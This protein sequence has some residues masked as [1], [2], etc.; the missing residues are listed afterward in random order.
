[1]TPAFSVPAQMIPGLIFFCNRQISVA[2]QGLLW[3]SDKNSNPRLPVCPYPNNLI[4][5]SHSFLLIF[6]L[7]RLCAPR[8]RDTLSNHSTQSYSASFS[9][10]HL[11]RRPLLLELCCL[12]YT[13]NLPE[14]R[15]TAILC[16]FGVFSVPMPH[17][18]RKQLG[19]FHTFSL[20]LKP[21]LSLQG[22]I[23]TSRTEM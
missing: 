11:I 13:H 18:N 22:I 10:Q 7:F 2:D 15:H 23:I 8:G 9:Q 5:L 4:S 14:E 1:M 19:C 6:D 20:S 12:N 17:D 3:D 16:P 21:I